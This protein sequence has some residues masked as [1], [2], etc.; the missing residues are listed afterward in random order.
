LGQKPEAAKSKAG[1]GAAGNPA[2]LPGCQAGRGAA[3]LAGRSAQA[4][5]KVTVRSVALLLDDHCAHHSDI[6]LGK[7]GHP[8]HLY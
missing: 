2:L 6:H 5:W 3:S 8:G 4:A 1:K 7:R